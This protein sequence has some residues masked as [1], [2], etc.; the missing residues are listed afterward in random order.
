M[1]YLWLYVFSFPIFHLV[2]CS[3]YTFYL[4]LY[5]VKNNLV[6]NM[7][8]IVSNTQSICFIFYRHCIGKH[9]AD[10]YVFTCI[11]SCTYVCVYI[12]M[13]LFICAHLV[14]GFCYI[15]PQPVYLGCVPFGTTFKKHICIFN[16]RN[17]FFGVSTSYVRKANDYACSFFF[18]R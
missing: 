14:I 9:T 1:F 5:F 18:V 3:K 16:S 8:Q 17:I 13:H 15:Y 7:I 2:W 11:L 4:D 6:L 10:I 12:C